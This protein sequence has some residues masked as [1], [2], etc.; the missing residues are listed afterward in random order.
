MVSFRYATIALAGVVV[1]LVLVYTLR[2]DGGSTDD[3]LRQSQR[4]QEELQAKWTKL[5]TE[6]QN[7][8]S[9]SSEFTSSSE[10]RGKS[11][12]RVMGKS[13]NC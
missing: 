10:G 4:R 8:R 6:L 2:S 1:L 3:T 13:R 11:I 9:Q 12:E 5:F 7:L